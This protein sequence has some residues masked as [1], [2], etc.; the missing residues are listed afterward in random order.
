M[1]A[2]RSFALVLVATF[3]A[4]CQST[5]EQNKA[6]LLSSAV[7]LHGNAGETIRVIGTARY[8][9]AVGPSIAGKDFDVRVYPANLWGPELDGKQIEVTG[10]LNDSS[11]TTPPD[12]SI[13]PGEYW[14]SDVKWA[15]VPTEKNK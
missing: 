4:G 1:H 11:N 2:A 15:P 12:P 6:P 8:L 3:V 10:R 5:E 7:Q 13:R 9:K 14:F